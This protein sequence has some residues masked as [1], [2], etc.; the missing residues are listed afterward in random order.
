MRHQEEATMTTLLSL[1]A[2]RADHPSIP[3]REEVGLGRFG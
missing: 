2:E 3:L 1:F